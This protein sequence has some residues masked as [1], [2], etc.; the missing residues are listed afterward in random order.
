M[1]RTGGI[2]RKSGRGLVLASKAKRGPGATAARANGSRGD[3]VL[4]EGE[5]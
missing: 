5:R 1:A 2:R 4:M 3:A